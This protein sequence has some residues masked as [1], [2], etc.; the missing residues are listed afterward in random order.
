MEIATQNLKIELENNL[1]KIHA[2]SNDP[3]QFAEPAVKLIMESI[4]KLKLLC[5]EYKFN[6]HEQEIKFFK[7]IKPIFISKLIYYN[8]IYT[9]ETNCPFGGINEYRNYYKAQL[10]KLR[11]FYKNNEDFYRYYKKQNSFLDHKYFLRGEP[12]IK[13]C[14]DSLSFQADPVFA[15]S[16]DFKVAQIMANDLLKLY[17]ENQINNFKKIGFINN[18]K[19]TVSSLKWTCSKVNLIEL[20]FALHTKGVFNNGNADL[21]FII[22]FF[23]KSFDIELGQFHRT[24]IEIASRKSDRTK[25]LIGLQEKLIH[26]MEEKEGI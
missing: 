17:L 18:N 24:F 8:E 22:R 4:K 14:L 12:D 1:E 9:I 10:T 16:H 6:N 25:F 26:R 20:I 5:L 3:M 19:Q 13:L 23:E 15:T 11:E 21:Q 7:E 2:N